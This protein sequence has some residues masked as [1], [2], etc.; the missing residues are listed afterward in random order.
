VLYV[1]LTC[2]TRIYPG[3]GH[4]LD[5][6]ATTTGIGPFQLTSAKVALGI[7]WGIALQ[8]YLLDAKIWRIKTDP[9]LRKALFKA[10]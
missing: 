4:I 1:A 6:G 2:A 3:C 8:H 9:E 10:V 5:A 7:Y